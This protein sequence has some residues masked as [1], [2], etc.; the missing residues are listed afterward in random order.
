MLARKT[1]SAK[2]FRLLVLASVANLVSAGAVDARAIRVWSDPEL[3][4]KSDLVVIAIPTATN[5]T[6]E[7]VGL[8]GLD[9]QP[10]VGVETKF[11]VIAVRKGEKSLKS[12]IL[13][14]YRVDGFTVPNGPNLV[15]FD[16]SKKQKFV[17]FLVRE[18]DVRYA[19]TV[20]QV[21]PGVSGIRPEADRSSR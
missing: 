19:P 6:K 9:H 5:D 16:I 8:P 1:G 20:G 3:V 12:L 7:R 14:H 18:K 17:L 13:H 2:S 15:S 11:E 4:E 21:D 10:V